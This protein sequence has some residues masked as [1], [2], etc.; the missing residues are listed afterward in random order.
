MKDLLKKYGKY[1]PGAV[2][3]LIH[4]LAVLLM[5]TGEFSKPRIQ[6]GKPFVHLIGIILMLATVVYAFRYP[7]DAPELKYGG[8]N[9]PTISG[10][11]FMVIASVLGWLLFYWGGTYAY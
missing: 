6:A 5:S 10:V 8:V 11:I 3:L 2:V 1:V 4:L 9:A 7:K